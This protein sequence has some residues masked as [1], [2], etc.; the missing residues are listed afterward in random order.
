LHG[1]YLALRNH[2]VRE[3]L[4]SF[5][6]LFFTPFISCFNTTS[7]SIA[8]EKRYETEIIEMKSQKRE[9]E[10]ENKR[11]RE[12]LAQ[13]SGEIAKSLTG[14]SAFAPDV[15][16]MAI[17]NTKTDLQKSEDK[18]AQ[19][20]YALNNSQGAMKKLDFYYDQFRGWAEEFE[21]ASLE[22]R[23]MIV[24]RLVREVKV[25]RG[26]ELDIVLDVNYEQFLSA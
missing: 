23:K 7:K 1:L 17:D 4:L 25:S 20:N 8:L 18:L 3:E 2:T 12:R 15:L 11:C 14:D 19:L 26:Y 10:Q 9:A 21:D 5:F 24:C 13:L 6:S 16:A 22:Q